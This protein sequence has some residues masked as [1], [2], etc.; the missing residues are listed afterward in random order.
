MRAYKFQI[1]NGI[2]G[3]K[4]THET[5]PKILLHV[6]LSPL[7]DCMT[8]GKSSNHTTMPSTY[9]VNTQK[10][11]P[12]SIMTAIVIKI[13]EPQFYLNGNKR[14]RKDTSYTQFPEL[15]QKLNKT[16]HVKAP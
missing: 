9:L 7:D 14:G 8:A 4:K 6:Q 13:P 16:E 3:G 10:I 5:C 1:H 2:V 15:W 12:I 11:L